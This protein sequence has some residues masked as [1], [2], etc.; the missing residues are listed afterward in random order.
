MLLIDKNWSLEQAFENINDTY[1][2]GGL[3][4]GPQRNR[5]IE[6]WGQLV[7]RTRAV[8]EL[9]LLIE[10]HGSASKM[11]KAVRMSA[12]TIKSLRQFFLSLPDDKGSDKIY[13]G[14]TVGGYFLIRKMA[15]GGSANIWRVRDSR[16]CH[17]AMKILKR[18]KGKALERFR[19]EIKV[20][21]S[22]NGLRGVVPINDSCGD[23]L[24][25]G[26]A[27][28]VMPLATPMINV[29]NDNTDP[30]D[31]LGCLKSLA[32]SLEVFHS[33]GVY[34]RDIKPDNL[35]NYQGDWCF[36]DFGIASFPD[37]QPLTSSHK[38]LGPLHFIAPEMMQHPDEASGEKADV[39]SFAKTMWVLLTGQ[40]FPPP[41][42]QRRDVK[43]I[44]LASW[45]EL[46][47]IG[48]IDLLIEECTSHDPSKRPPMCDVKA[49]IEHYLSSHAL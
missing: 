48:E 12:G 32:A 44:S 34:H 24:V 23:V 27:W 28:F 26:L 2:P 14:M 9:D 49:A 21:L 15:S 30:V 41:G 35:F 5:Q 10:Q 16:K 1:Y 17:Y 6:T 4:S 38:K 36:G 11:S 37:K 13:Q 33:R 20:V 29:I 31:V 39:Y 47:G 40:K 18:P 45:C 19:D 22:L 43:Q 46:N 7:G 3:L 42:E 8:A 25:D